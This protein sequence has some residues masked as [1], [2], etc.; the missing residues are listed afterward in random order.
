MFKDIFLK[1][2]FYVSVKVVNMKVDELNI[3]NLI[4]E[5]DIIVEVVDD[6]FI[7]VLIFR[8]VYEY[9]KKVV[10]V[11]GIVGFGDCENIKIKCGKNFL[12]IG[13]FVILI[14][15]KKFFVLKVVVVVVM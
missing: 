4:L 3:D 7:K 1:I 8:K 2:N 11:F 10:L 12:I 14:K 9:G 13:D 5:Y 15:E 6:E